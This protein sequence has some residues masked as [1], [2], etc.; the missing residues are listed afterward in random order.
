MG[1]EER[2]FTKKKK[3]K[4]KKIP[5]VSPRATRGIFVPFF[6][7]QRFG[8]ETYIRGKPG[9][10]AFFFFFCEQCT[11]NPKTFFKKKGRKNP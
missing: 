1:D 5:A 7:P 11:R 9:S 10:S 3:K 8:V 6:I 4:K 2:G